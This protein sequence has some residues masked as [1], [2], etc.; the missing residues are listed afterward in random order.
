M[1]CLVLCIHPIPVHNT[2][3]HYCFIKSVKNFLATHNWNLWT[4]TYFK[5]WVW[6]I[7]ILSY[8]KILIDD[9]HNEIQTFQGPKIAVSL[10][11]VLCHFYVV[12][13]LLGLYIHYYSFVDPMLLTEDGPFKWAVNFLAV[14]CY[15]SWAFSLPSWYNF[16]KSTLKKAVFVLV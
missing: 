6:A 13:P 11:G 8:L 4:S 3:S 14:W 12:C 2:F 5:T 9:N 10:L 1:E 15:H 16:E 7:F